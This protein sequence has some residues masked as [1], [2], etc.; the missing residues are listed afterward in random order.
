MILFKSVY[1]E[2]DMMKR[3]VEDF[4]ADLHAIDIDQESEHEI[5]P[6]KTR[7][8]Q[9]DSDTD[10]PLP[11][12]NSS[13]VPRTDGESDKFEEKY[14]NHQ[15]SQKRNNINLAVLMLPLVFIFY[16]GFKSADMDLKI[17]NQLQ[18]EPIGATIA[19]ALCVFGIGVL[20][21]FDDLILTF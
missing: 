1:V 8:I 20:T 11:G 3:F 12:R 13:P 14:K 6:V 10:G 2:R 16:M 17:G 9:L 7:D 5:S 4:E 18:V 21:Y 19:V 15:E